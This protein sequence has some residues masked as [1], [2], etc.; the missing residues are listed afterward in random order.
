MDFDLLTN[1]AKYLISVDFQS[2]EYVHTH[3]ME[4]WTYEDTLFTCRELKRQNFITSTNYG[5]NSMILIRLSTES[6]AIMENKFKDNSEKA[7][8][9]AVKIKSLIP[10]I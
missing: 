7:L 5:D 6:I 1:D 8:D 3:L 9:F 4:E 2:V 10:F